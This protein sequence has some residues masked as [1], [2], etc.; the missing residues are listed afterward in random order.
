[1]ELNGDERVRISKSM[2]LKSAVENMVVKLPDP[3]ESTNLNKIMM[4]RT[5]PLSSEGFNN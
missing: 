5:W 3:Q 4:T 2:A 1:M